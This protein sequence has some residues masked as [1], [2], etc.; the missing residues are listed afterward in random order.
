MRNALAILLFL[1]WPAQ[2]VTP[3]NLAA[4]GRLVSDLGGFT[5]IAR[6]GVQTL[7]NAGIITS[8]DL[9]RQT[10]EKYLEDHADLI[11]RADG[12]M[13]ATFA[14]I[15][16]ADELRDYIAYEESPL[17]RAIMQKQSAA[18]QTMFSDHYQPAV[19]TDEEKAAQE[20]FYASPQG[21]NLNHKFALALGNFMA[22]L[23]PYVQQISAGAA[24]Q[25]CNQGGDCSKLRIVRPGESLTPKP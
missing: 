16:T 22:Q 24:E 13:A 4:A 12:E 23:A 15:Y 21:K 3:D 19:L 1:A 11:A 6:V 8:P 14:R 7:I 18:S 20:A 2:A 17:G 25:Y 5:N 9:Y 10:Y